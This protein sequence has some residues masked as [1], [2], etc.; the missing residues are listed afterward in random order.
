MRFITKACKFGKHLEIALQVKY[1]Y[2]QHCTRLLLWNK[3]NKTH[4]DI[5]GLKFSVNKREKTGEIT[6][7]SKSIGSALLTNHSVIQS[8]CEQGWCEATPFT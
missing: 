5:F 8:E 6:I 2:S 1:G 4:K 3:T 7:S